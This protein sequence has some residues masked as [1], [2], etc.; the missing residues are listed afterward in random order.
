[1]AD[2]SRQPPGSDRAQGDSPPSS[3]GSSGDEGRQPFLTW[4]DAVRAADAAGIGSLVAFASLVKSL[5]NARPQRVVVRLRGARVLPDGV[6]ALWLE[7]LFGE[8][9]QPGEEATAAAAA[10]AASACRST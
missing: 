5:S 1:M 10:A 2:G 8:P 4:A 7:L 3:A 6:L 9:P